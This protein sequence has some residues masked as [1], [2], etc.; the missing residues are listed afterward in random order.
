M[1]TSNRPDKKQTWHMSM[2]SC[3]KGPTHHAYAWQIGPFWRIPSMSPVLI[4]KAIDYMVTVER[5][6]VS[7]GSVGQ[8]SGQH[9]FG[10]QHIDDLVQDCSNSSALAMEL[11]QSCTKPSISSIIMISSITVAIMMSCIFICYSHY[12]SCNKYFFIYQYNHFK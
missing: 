9:W 5:W 6:G 1:I 12:C 7:D 4:S 10:E 2:V 11:L 8:I 3:Q